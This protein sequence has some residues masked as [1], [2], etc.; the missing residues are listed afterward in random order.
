MKK[1]QLLSITITL[2]AIAFC[3]DAEP[4]LPHGIRRCTEMNEFSKAYSYIVHTNP[5]YL[6][7]D[8]DTDGKVDYAFAVK[9][10]AGGP[11]GIGICNGEGKLRVLGAGSGKFSDVPGDHFLTQWMIV[12]PAESEDIKHEINR[13]PKLKGDSIYLLWEDGIG[14]IYWDGDYKWASITF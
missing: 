9:P 8:F 11:N 4:L 7:G 2:S 12:A 10:I 13:L 3:S 5:Q 14:L 6:R 1:T